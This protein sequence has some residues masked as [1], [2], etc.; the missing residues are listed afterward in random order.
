MAKRNNK[1]R[2]SQALVLNQY[3]LSLFGVTSLEAL[4]SEMKDSSLEGYDENNVSNF[5]HTLI[6]KLFH[7]NDLNKDL[8]Y[9]Y[10]Q[11][12]YGHTAK[13]SEKRST[14]L[15]W[16]YFQY[17]SLLFTEIYLD[18]Y[19]SNKENL[20]MEL[21]EFVK[22]FNLDNGVL[23]PELKKRN[24]YQIEEFTD[25]EL[26]KLAFWNA[27]GS[28]KT[29]IM[30]INILQYIHYLKKSKRENELNRVILLT[31]NEGL[32]RQHI[33]EFEDSNLEAQ[34]FSKGGKTLL[35][36]HIIEVIDIHK[37]EENEGDKTVAV[38]SFEGNNLVL[39]DEGHRGS[40]GEEW[41]AKRNQLCEQGFSFEYSATFGQAVSAASGAKRDKL[42]Q[43]YAKCTLFDYSYKYFYNDGYGKDYHILNL[44]DTWNEHTTELYLTA[45]LLSFYQQVKV[46]N[47]NPS[48]ISSFLIEKP[49]W[50]FVGSKVT[51]VRKEN[52]K[53]VS[54]VVRIL[55]FLAEFVKDE[56][57]SVDYLDRL[58]EA[59]DGLIDKDNR[60][61]FNNAFTYLIK[62]RIPPKELYKDI[63]QEV[64]NSSVAGAILHIDNL[65]GAD[66]E[67]G[68]R[69][70]DGEYFSVINVGDDSKLMKLCEAQG[71][72]TNDKDFSTSLFHGINKKDSTINILIGSKK[73]TEGWSSWRVSTM[74]LMNI[75]RGEGSEIIQLFGRGV[76]LKGYQFSLKRSSMLDNSLKPDIVP[77]YLH[78]L[79]TLN[80][81]GI[82]AD[83]M[84]QFKEY[85]EEEG[86]PSDSG[87]FEEVSIIPTI[88]L[89]GK[90]LKILKVKDGVDFKKQIVFYLG[91]PNNNI[92]KVILDWYPKVQVLQSARNRNVKREIAQEVH[93]LN[94]YN[95]A[96]INWDNVY[97]E[98]QKFKNERSWYNISIDRNIIKDVFCTDDW[99]D[100]YIPKEELSLTRFDQTI[101][102][103]EI[104]TS[105]IKLYIDK[106]Y[107]FEK[108]K[109]LSKFLETEILDPTHPNFIEKYQFYIDKSRE[110]IVEKIKVLKELVESNQFKDDY[111]FGINSDVFEF[112]QHLY[113][114]LVY[115][116]SRSFKDIVKLSP[117][118]L[119]EGE[120]GFVKDLRIFYENN[121]EFFDGKE[122]YLLRNLSKKGIGFFEA[123]NFFPDFILWVLEGEKQIIK[124]IDPKGLRQINGFDNPK[125][126]FH[127]VIKSD[128][129]PK[130]NDDEVRLESYIVSNTALKD[131]KHWKGQDCIE[132]FNLNNVYFQDEQKTE[133]IKYILESDK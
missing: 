59:K 14:T 89:E 109:Y 20:K 94:S 54:D 132:D 113:K 119:N 122:L 16:K 107:N 15:K 68:V 29:L 101:V 36:G 131:L 7:N 126:K 44:N 5:Y 27:T 11:N 73:F 1:I 114:P 63:L 77:D 78:L 51:A 23:F 116:N 104:V 31:P 46:F 40:S 13:I 106:V 72:S 79:E 6:Y 71:I 34:F 47:E 130:L 74:G 19:F 125:I 35:S 61:I 111:A 55:T 48:Q 96:F 42:T 98:V 12:I 64:F 123:N 97:F 103:Q 82:R 87:N 17:L 28:G 81:F 128:I 121:P 124:F 93:K 30:H 133:Y 58:I 67:I 92:P 127:K 8:L 4:S 83:Y 3:I 50:I 24:E 117:V 18:K 32:S 9:S 33:K 26:N 99:Y 57:K 100:L 88:S 41:K 90:K 129:Q 56:H 66:G 80:I 2:L 38:G 22:K 75:G 65:K 84:Q 52:K 70:G 37:L 21:N 95:L 118:Q 102:W 115:F 108:N 69:I 45:C 120:K 76:R 110:D 43:E 60:S 62:K 10:D 49:L 86:L 91:L 112:S 39:V 85:L 53:D 105:L 25:F